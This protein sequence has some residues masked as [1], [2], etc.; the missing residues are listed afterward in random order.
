MGPENLPDPLVVA[1]DF[2][3]ILKRADIPYVI[4]GSV[5]SSVHGEPRSTHGVD[6]VVELQATQVRAL[7]TFCNR[8]TTSTRTQL[9][10]L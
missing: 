8:H 6:F 2:A 1:L 4:G 9:S 10:Q 3:S 7:T 5:A